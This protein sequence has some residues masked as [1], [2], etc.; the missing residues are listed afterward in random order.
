MDGRPNCRNKA[1]FSTT[2]TVSNSSR[3]MWTA[4]ASLKNTV[5]PTRK[6]FKKNGSLNCLRT[7]IDPLHKWR[8]NLREGRNRIG[9][10]EK[11]P[12]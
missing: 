9:R 8:L 7:F 12:K 2:D 3:V 5:R 4:R 11:W 1:A 10:R 6:F